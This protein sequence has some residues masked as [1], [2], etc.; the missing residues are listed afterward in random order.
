[1]AN[2]D[3]EPTE[4]VIAALADLG[5]AAQMHIAAGG[6]THTAEQAAEEAGCELGQIVKTL[7]VYVR[8][9][10]MFVLVAG[11]RKLD[12]RA[13]AGR[14]EVGRKQVRLASADEVLDVTG[15]R[16]GGVSPFGTLRRLDTLVDESFDRFEVVWL[17][18]G[19]ANAIFPMPVLDVLK[20]TDGEFAHVAT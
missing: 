14:F 5:F 8:T 16:V 11:D 20:L 7:V 12:D 15:Y 9:Q 3:A 2:H 17:A 13:L 4:R 1:L 18:G 19:T 6:A 10:P